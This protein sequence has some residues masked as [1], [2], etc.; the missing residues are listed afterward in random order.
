MSCASAGKRFNM[1]EAQQNIKMGET[2]KKQVLAMCGEPLSRGFDMGNEKEMWHYAYV[3]KNITG[4]G[5][6]THAVGVGDEWK[7]NASIMDVYFKSGVVVDL[8]CE[9]SNI[10]K[11]NLK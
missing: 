8:K 10:K 6:F 1:E 9:S 7:S 5:V 3:E 2:T 11:F 4:F